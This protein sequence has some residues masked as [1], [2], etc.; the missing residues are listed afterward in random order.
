[1]KSNKVEGKVIDDNPKFG[2]LLVVLFIA[3]LFV[4]FLTWLMET[5]FP[6]FGW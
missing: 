6:D 5:R 3:V 1:M 4:G 2:R